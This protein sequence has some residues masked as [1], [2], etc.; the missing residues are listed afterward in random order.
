MGNI[1]GSY[2]GKLCKYGHPCIRYKSTSQ[3]IDCRKLRD[4]S[5]KSKSKKREYYLIHQEHENAYSKKYYAEH[6]EARE[7][8]SKI[9][10]EK[11]KERISEYSKNYRKNNP[12]V[13]KE[14][15][16]KRRALMCGSKI[17]NLTRVE[18][19]AIKKAYLYRC[20]YCR[21][22]PKRLTQDH[23]TPISKGGNHTL[24]N[25][26][27]ACQPCNSKKHTGSPLTP[28]QPLLLVA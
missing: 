5:K 25:V 20:A 27:P 13:R 28:V 14:G 11:N 19:E 7:K 23:I 18:W 3:C 6:K 12:D 1:C 26:V 24:S 2:Q 4:T 9:Y 8:Y 16:K 21:S 22:K 15:D 17:S 10:Y